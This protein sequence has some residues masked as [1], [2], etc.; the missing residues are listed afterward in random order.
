MKHK[1]TDQQFKTAVIM[2]D[3]GEEVPDWVLKEVEDR[4]WEPTWEV[5]ELRTKRIN[6]TL[7]TGGIITMLSDEAQ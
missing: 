2:I 4:L 3:R 7:L 6:P 1:L 5:F